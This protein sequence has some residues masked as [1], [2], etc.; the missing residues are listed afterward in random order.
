MVIEGEEKRSWRYN[1]FRIMWA[2]LSGFLDNSETKGINAFLVMPIAPP[3]K[4]LQ[5]LSSS[6]FFN[7]YNDALNF[8]LY[9]FF[10]LNLAVRSGFQI[11]IFPETTVTG[12]PLNE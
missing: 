3:F 8:E 1:A 9:N 7:P 6:F 5:P 4:I 11:K 12:S 10:P 2:V